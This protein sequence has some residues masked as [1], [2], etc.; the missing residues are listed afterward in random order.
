MPHRRRESAIR[1][2]FTDAGEPYIS[3]LPYFFVCEPTLSVCH[4]M[5]Q[6]AMFYLQPN[7]TMAVDEV[8]TDCLAEY[9]KSLN[10]NT[11][12][13]GHGSGP[14]LLIVSIAAAIVISTI[15]SGACCYLFRRDDLLPAQS[16]GQRADETETTNKISSS[17]QKRAQLKPALKSPT[18]KPIDAQNS[19]A[20]E[21]QTT[22]FKHTLKTLK[23]DNR[24]TGFPA[25]TTISPLKSVK[26]RE[27]TTTGDVAFIAPRDEEV[28][29]TI[30]S[31]DDGQKSLEK[32]NL[33]ASG[34]LEEPQRESA[35]PVQPVPLARQDLQTDD[36]RGSQQDIQ[37]EISQDG[38]REV[39]REPPQ[40]ES[41]QE[42]LR[43]LSPKSPLYQTAGRD[44][45]IL[46]NTRRGIERA[47]EKA[48]ERA[49]E[50]VKERM[51]RK[52]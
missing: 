19:E 7:R 22:R 17:N 45:F 51:K 49:R 27:T 13:T 3:R 50:K 1:L 10:N 12:T 4:D 11:C 23:F 31:G 21:M 24:P 48:K 34:N 8:C 41:Q 40:R 52:K 46:N 20:E 29:K 9:C 5:I 42:T 35:R 36:K 28:P 38:Q 30:K 14:T 33:V 32:P 47:R 37:R 26:S 6:P 44:K 16:A 39:Q 18:P 43:K 2:N 25:K 15:V